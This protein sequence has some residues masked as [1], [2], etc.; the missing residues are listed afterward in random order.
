MVEAK[1]ENGGREET[2]TPDLY[3][4][5]ERLTDI[6]NNLESA[7]GNASQRKYVLS[8]DTVYHDVYHPLQR[9]RAIGVDDICR[10]SAQ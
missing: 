9:D 7:D 10:F 3:R 2:R 4:V 8:K 5:N 6:F 1:E